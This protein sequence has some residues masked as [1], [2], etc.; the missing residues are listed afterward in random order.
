MVTLVYIIRISPHLIL[1]SKCSSAT[2]VY[3]LDA[4]SDSCVFNSCSKGTRAGWI[5]VDGVCKNSKNK[6]SRKSLHLH[7]ELLRVQLNTRFLD[8]CNLRCNTFY[9]KCYCCLLPAHFALFG[10]ALHNGFH[11]HSSRISHIILIGQ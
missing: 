6:N 5:A 8:S 7:T 2:S 10:F 3:S 11:S 9:A 1:F 4:S